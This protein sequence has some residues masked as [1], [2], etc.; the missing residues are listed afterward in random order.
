[1]QMS[2]TIMNSA[3]V[4]S[5]ADRTAFATV[6]KAIDYDAL[7]ELHYL[8]NYRRKLPVNIAR[9]MENAHDWEHLP[10]VHPS[11]FAAIELIDSGKWG[12]RT[13]VALPSTGETQLLQLLVDNDRNYWATSVL[14]GSGQGVHIHTQSE[15]VSDDAIM[16][17][18]R[19]Y[20]DEAPATKEMAAMTLT[21]LQSLYTQLY[22]ED[23]TLMQGRQEALDRKFKKVESGASS[24]DLGPTNKIE[25]SLPYVF[26]LDGNRYCLNRW[27]GK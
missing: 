7:E 23:Q 19:F 26:E 6:S 9:M 17:D 14:A 16:V 10:F 1:M 13:K 25:Q 11:A 12:W 15:A 8:G 18:V 21:Y 27:Q 20:M 2:S 4:I 5:E 22:D 24:I 3:L